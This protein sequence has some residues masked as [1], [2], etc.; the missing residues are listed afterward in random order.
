MT[1]NK[2]LSL[3]YTDTELE[4]AYPLYIA[5]LIGVVEERIASFSDSAAYACLRQHLCRSFTDF[6]AGT[7]MRSNSRGYRNTLM[8][9]I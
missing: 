8:H 4:T 7:G 3:H 9:P 6:N 1:S 5:Q 2:T